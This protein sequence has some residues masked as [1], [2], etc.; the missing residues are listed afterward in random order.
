MG[1]RAKIF[2]RLYWPVCRTYARRIMGDKPAGPLT[3]KLYKPPFWAIHGYWP[4]LSAPR[5]FSERLWHR[6]L[7]DRDP[8]L[9]LIV[10]KHRV[11]D[12]VADRVGGEYLIPLLWHGA[13]PEEIP[14]QDL[15][16]RFV[17][18]T[19][20]GWYSNIIVED[21]AKLDIGKAKA[22]L[23]AWLAVNY[24]LDKFLGI[25]WAYK[26]V[27]PEIVIE[28]FIG[29]P[30]AWPVDYKFWCY[31]GSVDFVVM[32]F[33]RAREQKT[34][35]F[36]REFVPSAYAL[37]G[38]GYA[39]DIVRPENYDEMIRVAETLSKDFPFMRVD[40]YSVGGRVFFGEMTPYPNGVETNF[41]PERDDLILG[42]L[43]GRGGRAV[44]G[45]GLSGRR[46]NDM[47]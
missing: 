42:D 11:R 28:A 13:D 4:D 14:F 3:R 15:P 19:N 6:M 31:S 20:H 45:D 38:D 21:K 36:M 37:P 1:L 35:T 8:R 47:I 17:L 34:R 10:D 29:E 12:Y 44:R 18:K 33:D 5:R 16:S 27:P 43:W 30:G 23:A 24:C 41:V 40:L 7:T 46:E 2:R 22:Q 25:E 32:H 9:T 39:G 26:N